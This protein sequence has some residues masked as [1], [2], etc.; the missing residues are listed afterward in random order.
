[1]LGRLCKWLAPYE[2]FVH[3]DAKVDIAPFEDACEGLARI[4]F[5]PSR[6][7]VNWAGYSQVRAMT[8]LI[9]AALPKA[10][11]DEHLVM[12]SGQDFPIKPMKEL[13][14]HLRINRDTQFIRAFAIEGTEAKYE[15]QL[16]K[17]HHRDLPLLDRGAPYTRRFRNAVIRG[18][19]YLDRRPMPSKPEHLSVIAHGSTQ[20]ALTAECA[21]DILQ[22]L[23]AD[24]ERYFSAV[25]APD[26]K[27]FH[28]LVASGDWNRRMSDGGPSPYVGPGNY[29]YTNFHEISPSHAVRDLRDWDIVASSDKYFVRKVV[30]GQ[31]D[32]LIAKIERDLLREKEH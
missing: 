12:L 6:V 11:P 7:P 19:E 2:V 1:M 4:T 29:R 22:R 3:I 27:V 24:V 20:W 28:S 15:K 18:V 8:S 25:F 30:S 5:V 14:H 26:E 10:R 21:A 31:S 9:G 17:R 32:S 23:D 13:D 16:L